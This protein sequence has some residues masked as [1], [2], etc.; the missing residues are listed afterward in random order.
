[1]LYLLLMKMDPSTGISIESNH[2]KIEKCKLQDFY[3]HIHNMIVYFEKNIKDNGFDYANK[4]YHCHVCSALSTGPNAQFNKN[5][6]DIQWDVYAGH[7][8]HSNISTLALFSSAQKICNNLDSCDE[9]NAV[10][11]KYVQMMALTMEI[12]KLKQSFTQPSSSAAPSVHASSKDSTDKIA[13]VEKWHMI[14]QGDRLT[15][16]GVT[17]TWYPHH[18]HP[19]WL[20]NGLYYNNHN[21][22]N[23]SE[24]KAQRN[25]TW[26]HGLTPSV[27]ASS[28]SALE[29]KKHEIVS[30]LK[31]SLVRNLCVLKD[32][33][34]CDIA[35]L[36]QGN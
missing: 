14:K 17:Y 10:D 15:H 26:K 25:T 4:T 13:G 2:K 35:L 23:H 29:P 20:Y 5:I 18:K 12:E 9:W 11:P 27:N 24:W 19:R 7:D 6:K 1:M 36:N 33:I 16:N 22:D 32:D 31:Y 30:Q 8:H 28:N 21:P 3:N 34:N